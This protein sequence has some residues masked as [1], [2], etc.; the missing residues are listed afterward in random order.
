MATSLDQARQIAAEGKEVFSSTE[1][2]LL[3]KNAEKLKSR[4]EKA[5]DRSDKLLRKLLA[6]E[7]DLTKYRNEL[8]TFTTWLVKAQQSLDERH[9]ALGTLQRNDTTKEFVIDVIA[10]QADLRFLGMAAQKFMDDSKDHLSVLNEY[11]V[12]LPQRLGHL[13]PRKSSL[14]KQELQEVTQAYQDLL[15]GANKLSDRVAGVGGRQKDYK[16]ALDKARAWLKEAEIRANKCLA[17]PVSAEPRA[18]EEQLLKTK[19]LH[20][21]FISNERLIITA[22]TTTMSLIKSLEGEL[23]PQ[24]ADALEMPARELENK[25]RQLLDALGERCQALDTALVQSQ[26]VQDALDNLGNW[27]NATEGQLK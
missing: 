27:L 4:Y 11:R 20:S 25:Y 21:E 24:D 18:V 22:V 1:V 12:S 14:V 8:R 16:D 15:A 26:G 3:E 17:E 19:S 13:E 23:S 6:G 5:S 10:H 7:E 2:A 9:K